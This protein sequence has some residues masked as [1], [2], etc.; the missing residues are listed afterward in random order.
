MIVD[1]CVCTNQ[2]FAALKRVRDRHGLDFDA[3]CQKTECCR[4]CT[5]C[6]PYIREMIRT[7]RTTFTV[8]THSAAH[9]KGAGQ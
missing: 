2:T 1:R 5:M 3:L 7:G 9:L 4:G 6:A 8:L